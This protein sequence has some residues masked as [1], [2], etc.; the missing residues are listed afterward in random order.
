MR[1]K[2]FAVGFCS[3]V[4]IAILGLSVHLVTKSWAERQ[5]SFPIQDSAEVRVGLSRATI[6][7]SLERSVTQVGLGLPTALPIEFRSLLDTQRGKVDTA[8]LNIRK[9]ATAAAELPNQESFLTRLDELIANLKTLR[10]QADT[11]LSVVADAR[12][13]E[14][15]SLP[16]EFK[17]LVERFHA[18]GIAL[19]PPGVPI[20]YRVGYELQLQD[21]AWQM[22]EYGGR[23]RTY[24]AI[25]IATGAPLSEV[26]LKE[27]SVLH[28]L[29]QKSWHEASILLQAPNASNGVVA[30]GETI[31]SEYFG[32]YN[33]LRKQVLADAATGTYSVT[34]EDFF[35]KSSKALADIEALSLATGDGAIAE[36]K[37]MERRAT[38]NLVFEVIVAAILLLGMACATWYLTRRVSHRLS[39]LSIE[40]SKLADGDYSIDITQVHGKDEIGD[41][42]QTVAIFQETAKEVESMRSSQIEQAAAAEVSKRA[43]LITLA[44]NFESSVAQVVETV[45]SAAIELEAT[46]A[47]L[48]RTAQ[49]T[50][51][52]S[53][54]VA[55]TADVS[56]SNVQTVASASE[57]LSASIGGIAQQ[58]KQAASIAHEAE[59]KASET[60]ATVVA[61][62]VAAGKIGQVIGLISDIASQTNLLALNATIE[63]ARA[64][65]AG[66]GFAVVASE[67][68]S[69]A[70]QTARATDEIS[71]QIKAVQ[72]ATDE[73]VTAIDSING[74]ISK[75]SQISTVISAAVE[76][77][78]AAVLEISRS[79]TNVAAAT[80]EVSQAIGLVQQGSSETGAAAEQSLG[81]ARELG[82]QADRLKREVDGFL[83]RVR[84]A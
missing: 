3:F 19:Q 82:Q 64:G 37:A 77:Q 53:N 18:T 72:S 8:L 75:I 9:S 68:K 34:F 36:A 76:E 60:N 73:A 55:R 22:R 65:D 80:S 41:M 2:I 20:P 69:L 44:D 16:G 42:V 25:A 58:V 48:T 59:R 54:A 15:A 12:T 50:E 27:M 35:A 71:T 5:N 1:I 83:I 7:M 11:G 28:M 66:K 10:S 84:A 47:T 49:D 13:A 38:I 45:A 78:M 74:T 43:V 61:L 31:K 39:A 62:S 21:L 51:N 81:A 57:E 52:H 46:S 40:M 24:M 26:S 32:S 63:A 14:S 4:A 70:E 67:V 33:S 6:L 17:V 56:A 29:A 23:E 30:A 79:S